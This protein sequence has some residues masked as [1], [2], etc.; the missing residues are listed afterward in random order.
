MIF[1]I[2]RHMD[3]PI[4]TRGLDRQNIRWRFAQK[5]DIFFFFETASTAQLLLI[6]DKL[7]TRMH[8][9]AILE[10]FNS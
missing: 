6:D 9:K 7:Y 10:Y 8:R 1:D 2:V 3:L 4:S 5:S